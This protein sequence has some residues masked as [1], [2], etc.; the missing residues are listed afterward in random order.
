MKK[1]VKG[2]RKLVRNLNKE[3]QAM[4][5]DGTYHAIMGVGRLI[6]DV[7][8]DGT[9]EMI[10]VGDPAETLNPEDVFTDLSS[11]PSSG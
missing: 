4:I 2:S 9:M 10:I 3:I 7:D 11:G 1:Q 5:K 8:G 6:A